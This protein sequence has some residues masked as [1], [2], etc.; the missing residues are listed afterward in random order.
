[1]FKLLVTISLLFIFIIPNTSAEEISCPSEDTSVIDADTIRLCDIK[2]RLFGISAAERGHSSYKECKSLVDKII[3]ES[4]EVR[5]DLTGEKTYDRYVGICEVVSNH[6]S[7]SLQ[8]FIVENDC[9]RDCERY[10]GG[11]YSIY[12]KEGAKELP[13][14]GYCK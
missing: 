14:P 4:D 12:E 2:I 13:L 8:Q 3:R 10:S 9:A 11:I 1:M 7:T 5:C 6:K